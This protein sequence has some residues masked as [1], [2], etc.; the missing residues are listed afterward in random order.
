ME[1]PDVWW[2][3]LHLSGRIQVKRFHDIR[4]VLDAEESEFCKTV[5]YPFEADNREDAVNKIIAKLE[6]KGEDK[7]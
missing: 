1:K 4:D 6:Q 7:K 3:Y 5:F 2:G